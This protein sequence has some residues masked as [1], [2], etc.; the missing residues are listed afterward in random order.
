[1]PEDQPKISLPE[2]LITLMLTSLS[3]LGDLIGLFLFP[4]PVIG[5][6]IF[7]GA[8]TFNFIVWISIQ[9]WLFFRGIRG[10]YF[11]VGG[12]AEEFLQVPAQTLTLLLTILV[13]NNPKLEKAAEVATL[14]TA[15]G[16]GAATGQAAA[17]SGRGVAIGAGEEGAY[18]EARPTKEAVQP[19]AREQAAEEALMSESAKSPLDI[20][21]EKLFEPQTKTASEESGEDKEEDIQYKEAA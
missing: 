2:A 8:K 15:T 12:L 1:M 18:Q 21:Q 6:V 17:R 19:T 5:Q 7:F 4:L 3:D 9:L 16:A 13:V 20:A 14:T 11:L 10:V